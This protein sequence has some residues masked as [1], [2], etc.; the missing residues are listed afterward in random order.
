MPSKIQHRRSAVPG[1][2]PTT[3]QVDLGELAVNTRDGKLFLKRD[4]GNGTFT[5]IEIGAVVSVAGKMG[6]V[7]LT[8]AD[9][10]LSNVDN[11]ADT[12]KP[13]STAAQAALN[14]KA[15]AARSIETGTGLLGGGNLSANRTLSADIA[16]VEQAQEGAL[17]TKLM[18]PASVEQHMLANAIGWG[19]TI[20]SVYHSG[21]TEYTNT[22]GRPTLL[23]YYEN[24]TSSI[25]RLEVSPDGV[26]F[27]EVASS[28]YGV[29]ASFVIPAGWRYRF[30]RTPDYVVLLR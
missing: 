9:V 5:I 23:S 3:A 18:S 11:T 19:Q 24:S 12:A 26:V 27:T 4:N 2:V 6:T 15:D 28:R 17:N 13:I 10:G 1:K 8:K 30:N 20:S 21:F 29:S 22:T 7:T 14:A 25:C 16:T